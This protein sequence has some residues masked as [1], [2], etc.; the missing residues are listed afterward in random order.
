MKV[1]T[2]QVGPIMTNCYILCDDV[3]KVCAIVDPG[4]NGSYI[5]RAVENLGC[6]PVA[7]FMTH[8][9]FDHWNGLGE[10][11]ETYPDLP[12][13]IHE[14]EVVDGRGGDLRF[15][16]LGEHNQRYY[17]EGDVLTVGNLVLRVMETPG[18]SPGS[19]CLV[20]GDT[21]FSGDTLF[22]AN[23]GRCDFPGGDYRKMLSSLAR[24]GRMEGQY[25]VYPGHEMST[26][27][28]FERNNNPYMRQGMAQ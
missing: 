25:T 10:V 24:L 6:T 8:G 12:V 7:V 14:A 2:L 20:T 15:P 1:S 19:V 5:C 28:N 22:R 17:K 26:D 11:L 16:R 4:D 13:Y 18:H 9:H 21:I 23:C 3:S 27:M